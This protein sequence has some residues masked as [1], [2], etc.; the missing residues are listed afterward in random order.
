MLLERFCRVR[1]CSL[2][3][4]LVRKRACVNTVHAMVQ[5]NPPFHG[6]DYIEKRDLRSRSCQPYPAAVSPD[7][8]QNPLADQAAHKAAHKR[9]RQQAALRNLIERHLRPLPQTSQM[10]DNAGGVISMAFDS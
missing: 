5:R 3:R 8:A 1:P 7:S 6:I 10:K 9:K 2:H 4:A